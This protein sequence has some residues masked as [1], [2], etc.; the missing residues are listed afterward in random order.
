VLFVAQPDN[1]LRFYWKFAL[2]F[3]AGAFYFLWRLIKRRRKGRWDR[4]AERWPVADAPVMYRHGSPSMTSISSPGFGLDFDE[5]Q[6]EIGYKVEFTYAFSLTQDGEYDYFS[7]EFAR[8]FKNAEQ[9][10]AWLELLRDKRIPVRFCPADPNR[11]VVLRSDIQAKFP[12]PP[13]DMVSANS[14]EAGP[15]EK[16]PYTFLWPTEAAFALA[17]AGFTVGMVVHLLLVIANRP[18]SPIMQIALWAGYFAVIMPYNIWFYRKSPGTDWRQSRTKSSGPAWLLASIL[19]LNIYLASY[20]LISLLGDL[21]FFGFHPDRMRFDPM[22]NGA[23]VTL[24]FAN[25]ALRCYRRLDCIDP[26]ASPRSYEARP[27]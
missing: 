12:V 17:A 7:G 11:S 10:A 3:V 14:K 1:R 19:L 16:L 27:E 21:S 15:T 6:R 20:W 22:A 13:A 2:L 26:L 25:S 8:S 4:A 18:T 24:M 5:G 23:M 9:G